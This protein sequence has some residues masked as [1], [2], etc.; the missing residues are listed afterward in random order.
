MEQKW[1]PPGWDKETD[2]SLPPESIEVQR[3]SRLR[4][5][6]EILKTPAGMRVFKDMMILC[7]VFTEQFKG[8]TQTYFDQGCRAVALRYWNLIGEADKTLQAELS[9]PYDEFPY[10]AKSDEEQDLIK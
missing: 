6:E 3:R 2:N 10:Q 9:P 5:L 4:D 7:G 1:T 8:N